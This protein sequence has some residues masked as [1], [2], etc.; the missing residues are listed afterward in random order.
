MKQFELQKPISLHVNFFQIGCSEQSNKTHD[1]RKI[2]FCDITT[3]EL[4]RDKEIMN[5]GKLGEAKFSASFSSSRQAQDAKFDLVHCPGCTY[6]GTQR[7]SCSQTSVRR[8]ARE[9]LDTH[10]RSFECVDPIRSCYYMFLS[11]SLTQKPQWASDWIG[12]FKGPN[13]CTQ[14][15]SYVLPL[16]LPNSRS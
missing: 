8:N 6:L 3:L 4:C 13:V 9:Y 15:F 10:V 1:F 7:F 5:P 14:R 11:Q 12:V 16:H 2:H